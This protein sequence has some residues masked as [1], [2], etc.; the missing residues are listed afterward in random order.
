MVS[1]SQEGPLLLLLHWP[2]TRSCP[3]TN[4]SDVMDS[5]SKRLL[6][7][8]VVIVVLPPQQQQPVMT[9]TKEEEDRAPA[10]AGVVSHRHGSM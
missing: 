4:A 5:T 10:V 8:R 6:L 9:T 7:L 3:P 2:F 1:I